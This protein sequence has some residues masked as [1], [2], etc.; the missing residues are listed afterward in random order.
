MCHLGL[1]EDELHFVCECKQ[2]EHE[3]KIMFDNIYLTFNEFD[4]LNIQEKFIYIMQNEYKILAKYI[5]TAWAKRQND[6]F[7]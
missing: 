4:V 3:R 7:V 5:E 2:Y 6:I 1:V